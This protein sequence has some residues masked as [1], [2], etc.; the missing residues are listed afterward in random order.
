VVVIILMMSLFIWFHSCLA[1]ANTAM[2]DIFL[3]IRD[4]D[5]PEWADRLLDRMTQADPSGYQSG[6]QHLVV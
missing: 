6:K 4:C 3:F 5:G 1:L 2:E